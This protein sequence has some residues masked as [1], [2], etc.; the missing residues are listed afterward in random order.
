[1]IR[2]SSVAILV[3]IITLNAVFAE[4]VPRQEYTEI[5]G[6]FSF[7]LA[8]IQEDTGEYH[9]VIFR[10]PD[11][12]TVAVQSGGHIG[13]PNV[14]VAKDGSYLALI[15]DRRL[16]IYPVDKGLLGRIAGKETYSDLNWIYWVQRERY[17]GIS[18]A[19][20]D[21]SDNLELSFRIRDPRLEGSFEM[22]YHPTKGYSFAID[23]GGVFEAY[24]DQVHPK[25]FGVQR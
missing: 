2:K 11:N 12:R 16:E 23:P 25:V 5:G 7:R 18:G 14:A 17:E 4:S 13:S 8:A 6:G 15:R 10:G 24:G 22:K 21:W 9:I 1:M 19:G 20:M 3:W